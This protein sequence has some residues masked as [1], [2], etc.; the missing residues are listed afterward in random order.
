MPE[1]AVTLHHVWHDAPAE[2]PVLVLL[3]GWGL[4]SGVWKNF[5]PLL[6]NDFR[7]LCI[8][9]PGFGSSTDFPVRDFRSAVDA[10]LALAP[11]KA[12]WLGWSLGGLFALDI[13]ARHPQR[14]QALSL[15]AATPCFVQRQDWPVAMA[16]DAFASFRATVAE[17]DGSALLHFLALQCKGSASMKADLRFL[18][19]L[20]AEAAAPS[21]EALL[22]GLDWLQSLDRRDALASLSMPLQC[23]LGQQDVLIPAA[24]ENAV[25][26]M[27]PAASCMTVAGAAHLPFA[28]HPEICATAL[29]DFCR[30]YGLLPGVPA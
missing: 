29:K 2:A 10:V 25:Q 3:H 7:M 9:L 5:I 8:D 14:V 20:L 13:A 22:S 24:L 27:Q 18:Q 11:E 28:S 30:Q 6:Q 16:T 23:V 15:F 26:A 17:D 21:A 12:V 1:L 19:G 4:H